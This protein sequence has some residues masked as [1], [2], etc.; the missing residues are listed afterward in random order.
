MQ[1]GAVTCSLAIVLRN[2]FL[3]DGC[4]CSFQMCPGLQGLWGQGGVLC[5]KSAVLGASQRT[6]WGHLSDSQGGQLGLPQATTAVTASI[7]TNNQLKSIR[8]SVNLAAMIRT[9]CFLIEDL[10]AEHRKLQLGTPYKIERQYF[11][12]IFFTSL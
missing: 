12:K 11:P 3:A 8:V 2:V 6:S 9:K 1:Q 10:Y 7:L 4:N 5:I